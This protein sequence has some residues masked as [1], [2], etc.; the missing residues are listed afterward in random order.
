MRRAFSKALSIAIVAVLVTIGIKLTV[1]RIKAVRNVET[2]RPLAE[3]HMALPDGAKNF[4]LE[5]A[6]LP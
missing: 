2:P 4:P 1:E 5:L 6:P 3:S